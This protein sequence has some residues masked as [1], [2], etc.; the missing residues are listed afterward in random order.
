MIT[1][2]ELYQAVTTM[3]LSLILNWWM[4]NWKCRPVVTMSSREFGSRI[5][6]KVWRT[7]FSL[8]VLV[9][10]EWRQ[11]YRVLSSPE[12]T[13][14]LKYACY[15]QFKHQK[16]NFSE[17]EILRFLQRKTVFY[18]SLSKQWQSHGSCC[19]VTYHPT[20]RMTVIDQQLYSW[21]TH[22]YL[23]N[24]THRTLSSAF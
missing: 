10:V 2:M 22:S 12:V 23:Q 11:S 24:P 5:K 6:H 20:R 16:G 3:L 19:K 4:K 14:M 18:F 1:N 9:K 17:P 8:S 13:N 21:V 7:T 15:F